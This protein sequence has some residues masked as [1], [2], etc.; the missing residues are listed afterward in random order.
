MG[1]SWREAASAAPRSDRLHRR[2]RT[3]LL[4]WLALVLAIGGT[5]AAETV[6]ALQFRAKHQSVFNHYVIVHRIGWAE[7]STD[8][9]G[10]QGDFCVLHLRRPIPASVLAAQTFALMTRY[11][12]MDGGH[13]LTIEYADPHT[14]RAV[15]Q[16]DAVYDPA[17]HRLLMTLHEGDRLVTVERRVDWQDDR[18]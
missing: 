15:I 10:L 14:G 17:S 1:P 3:L 13:S 18:T 2:N 11:H 7:V 5:F 12:A 6:R 8:A 9:L 4:A 16:A